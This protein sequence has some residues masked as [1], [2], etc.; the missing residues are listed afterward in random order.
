MPAALVAIIYFLEGYPNIHIPHS[1]QWDICVFL[2]NFLKWRP[3]LVGSF[4]IVLQICTWNI[5]A[6]SIE[7]SLNFSNKVCSWLSA[8]KE[9]KNYGHSNSGN[10]LHWMLICN[11]EEKNNLFII[12]RIMSSIVEG[13]IL[14]SKKT[15][16]C[17]NTFSLWMWLFLEIASL[18][19]NWVKIR[20]SLIRVGPNPV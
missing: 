19:C 4:I 15:C 11:N 2:I 1:L 7:S 5:N 13:W 6:D 14:S 3:N 12:K 18:R 16:W 10:A 20:P 8:Y 9:K 17:P